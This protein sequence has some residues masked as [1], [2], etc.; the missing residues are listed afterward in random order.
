MNYIRTSLVLILIIFSVSFVNPAMADTYTDTI[1]VFIKSAAVQ[2]FFNEA[3]GY[4]VFPRIGKAGYILGGAYGVGRV[5][6]QGIIAGTSEMKNISLGLQIGM[7]MFSQVI[8]FK[9]KQ[10]YD[11]FTSGNFV[12]D[13]SFSA[14]VLTVGTQAHAGT[15]G[16]SAGASIGPATGVQAETDYHNGIVIFIHT[17]GGLMYEMSISGQK[18]SF[19][20]IE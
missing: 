6:K 4:A 5:Y 19:T 3:Y 16:S 17:L 14:V 10:A 8:F 11:S 15:G 1:D 12:F 7:Q 9:D 20:P 18:F 2:P 13:G